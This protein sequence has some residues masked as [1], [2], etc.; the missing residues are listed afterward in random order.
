MANHAYELAKA[1]SRWYQ[2][3]P[4]LSET[5]PA[6]RDARIA[7]TQFIAH[8][9]QGAMALLGIEMPAKM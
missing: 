1:F 5:D 4:I 9:I 8:Q 7:L 2:D 6:K 3:H